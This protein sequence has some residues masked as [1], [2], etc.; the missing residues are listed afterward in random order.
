MGT[1]LASTL[2]SK[3]ANVFLVGLSGVGLEDS[4]GPLDL[5][6]VA[7]LLGC[8][9]KNAG[10]LKTTRVRQRAAVSVM[11]SAASFAKHWISWMRLQR[12]SMGSPA[13]QALVRVLQLLSISSGS[14]V[15]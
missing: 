8:R 11:A 9:G 12:S 5:G 15:T 3:L 10:F 14:M 6:L 1:V 2:G 7:P 4:R 13:F